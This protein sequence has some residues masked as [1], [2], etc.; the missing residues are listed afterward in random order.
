MKIAEVLSPQAI[1]LNLDH[2]SKKCSIASLVSTLVQA[3][4]LQLEQEILD[5]VMKRETDCSTGIGH[6]IAFPHAQITALD[7]SYLA[8]GRAKEGID[9]DCPDSEPVHFVFLLVGPIKDTRHHLLILATLSRL[10][11]KEATRDKLLKAENPS[12]VM[13]ILT[14]V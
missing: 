12:E 13:E 4:G 10:M 6:G 14:Q 2:S 7:K 9:Y 5:H 8:F 3:N 1:D 11:H